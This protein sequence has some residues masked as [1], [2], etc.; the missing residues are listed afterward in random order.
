M[1]SNQRKN[2]T[3]RQFIATTASV[4]AASTTGS[5]RAETQQKQRKN[6]FAICPNSYPG[7]ANFPQ[8]LNLVKKTPIRAIELPAGTDSAKNLIPEWMVDVPLSGKWQHSLPDL[9]QLLTKDHFQIACVGT[10]GYL[11]YPG[12]E[13]I[14]KRRIDFASQLDTKVVNLACDPHVTEKHRTF[15]YRMLRDMGKYAA[16]KNICIALETWGGLTR[17]AE[18]SLRTMQEIGLDNVGINF[19]SGNVLLANPDMSP[20]DLVEELQQLTKHLVY[21]HLKDVQRKQNSKAITTV[22]G[23]GDIDFPKL[24]GVLHNA[25]YYGPFGF[26]LETTRSIQSHDIRECHKDL[27]ASLEYLKS[28]GQFDF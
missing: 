28:I 10:V 7:F 23:Q 26:D 14:I 18:E 25:G 2:N 5:L 17:N 24:F 1:K 19:D 13:R 11:G 6:S 4:L 15:A 21:I 22:L 27:L 3:R 16:E 12:S 9:K 20:T 8:F